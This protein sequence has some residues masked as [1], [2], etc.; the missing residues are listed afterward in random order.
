MNETANLDRT[1]D[2]IDY[3]IAKLEQIPATA[4]TREGKRKKGYRRMWFSYDTELKIGED[5][6]AVNADTMSGM[7]TIRLNDLFVGGYYGDSYHGSCKH[8]GD[9][10]V[11]K[12]LEGLDK[13]LGAT[14][15]NKRDKYVEKNSPE[16]LEL[17]RKYREFLGIGPN[18]GPLEERVNL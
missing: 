18:N 14:C 11:S 13:R 10:R 16:H 12:F 17:M 15:K 7:L 4:W 2:E 1:K 5:V 9:K 8:D 6:F 3:V